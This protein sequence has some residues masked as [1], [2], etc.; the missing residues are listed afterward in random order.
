MRIYRSILGILKATITFLILLASF[1]VRGQTDSLDFISL[2]SK[3]Q[4]N[5]TALNAWSAFT[6]D[7]DYELDVDSLS[8][9]IAADLTKLLSYEQ[10]RDLE[11]K[12]LPGIYPGPRTQDS[13][14]IRIYSF[15]YPS[16]GS[17]GDIFYS[18]MQWTNEKDKL[19]SK[20]LSP[21]MLR[22]FHSTIYS[23]SANPKLYLFT[24]AMRENTS[25]FAGFA[26]VFRFEGD[27]CYMNYPAF[28]SRN[29]LYVRNTTV[30]YDP[31]KKILHLA[32]ENMEYL[33][34]AMLSG[35]EYENSTWSQSNNDTAGN[36]AY[37]NLIMGRYNSDPNYPADHGI[38]LQWNGKAFVNVG[39]ADKADEY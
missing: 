6:P 4:K 10:A 15:S 34:G 1:S 39:P 3:L 37:Y 27:S 8:V 11:L 5:L 32:T 35:L 25:N 31:Q 30:T 23:L 19:C 38:N 13:T 28:A 24:G 16:R 7:H 9:V 36:R 22:G 17:A 12:E 2:K 20:N 21:W 26:I 18:V 33:N 14:R 29:M